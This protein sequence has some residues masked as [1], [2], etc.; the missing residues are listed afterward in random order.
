MDF[1][2]KFSDN[3]AVGSDF[4]V[5]AV[6]TNNHMKTKSCTVLFSAKAVG[7]SGKLG[8]S[9]AFASDKVELTPGEG[10]L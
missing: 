8:D 10:L 5:Y 9:C 3:M 6:L 7:Y 2:I 4:E 1:K